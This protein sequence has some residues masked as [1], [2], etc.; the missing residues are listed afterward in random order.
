MSPGELS[1]FISYCEHRNLWRLRLKDQNSE[2]YVDINMRANATPNA[3]EFRPLEQE[4]NIDG[5]KGRISGCDQ[6]HAGHLSY[7]HESVG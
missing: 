1:G 6:N 7:D 3:L 5:I 2:G 4:I